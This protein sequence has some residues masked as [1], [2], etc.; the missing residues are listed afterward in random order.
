[1]PQPKLDEVLTLAQ[2]SA[3]S[4]C[5]TDLEIPCSV[6]IV[7]ENRQNENIMGIE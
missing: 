3:C 7:A 2:V 6:E 5:K 4:C 1:L